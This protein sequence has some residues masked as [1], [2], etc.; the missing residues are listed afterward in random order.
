M[1]RSAA[2]I[3]LAL[4]LAIAGL[5]PAIAAA[6]AADGP[7][8][9]AAA[10]RSADIVGPG[11]DAAT[12]ADLGDG[13]AQ[14][15]DIAADTVILRAELEPDGDAHW[16]IAYRIKL[17]DENTTAA[18]ESLQADIR[19][20]TSAYAERFESRMQTTVA[21]AENAT[22]REMSLSNVSVTAQ[23]NP[24]PTSTDYGVVAYSFDWENFAETQGRRVVAG[25]ALAGLY[26][27]SGTILTFAWPEEYDARTV[28]PAADQRSETA[29]TWRGERNFGPDQPSVTIAPASAL[30]VRP[31]YLA[32]AAVLLLGIA[33]AALLRRRGD[34]P[35]ET[36]DGTDA[37]IASN[38]AATAPMDSAASA[39]GS[40]ADGAGT[41]T[42]ADATTEANAESGAGA[43]TADAGGVESTDGRDGTDAD[44]APPEELLSPHERVVR[45][46]ED[47]GGR[48]KQADVT[49][50]LDWSA[51][52]TSQVVGDLRD[53]GDIESF[54]LGRE[55]VLRL[56]EADD[57]PH[58]GDIDRGDGSEE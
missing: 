7:S 4:L 10:S 33:G 52:R 29:V 47:N 9:T 27:D 42:D 37:S 24:F 15:G 13:F 51:A 20:N 40:N 35:I 56:P 25:D 5:T 34:F 26:L 11:D 39:S 2:A 55:N 3:A 23:R 30:P 8:P 45:L 57:E 44:T 32:G 38:D 14:T 50:A 22:G 49:A 43:S 18:F 6:T 12:P 36:G 54:R 58:P 53:D 1:R 28:S 31:V 41:D 19:A 17:S 21:A 48:M 46:V 16:R